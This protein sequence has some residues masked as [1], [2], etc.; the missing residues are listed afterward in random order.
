MSRQKSDPALTAL[1]IGGSVLMLGGF[2]LAVA[3]SRRVASAPVGLPRSSEPVPTPP[4]LHG[5]TEDDVEAAARMLASENGN[6]SRA[7][8]TELLGSQ[9]HARK[10]GESLYERITAGSGF[11]PQGEKT[12]PGKLRPVSTEQS[13]MPIHRS[14]ALEV[15][16]GLHTPRFPSAIAFFEPAQQD[17]VLRIAVRARE[18]RQQGLPLT[19]QEE[20]LRHYKKGA[21]DVRADWKQTMRIAGTIDGVEFYEMSRINPE[22][23]DFAIRAKAQRLA[24]PIERAEVMRVGDGVTDSRPGTGNPHDGVDI[25]AAPGTPIRAARSGRVKRVIDGRKSERE[26]ARKAGLWV[27]LEIGKQIDR[28]LHLDDVRV[29]EGQQVKRGDLIG[30]VAEAY[31]SG[32]GKGPH[33][34]F[35]VRASDYDRDK[36]DYGEPIQ[37]K[38]EVV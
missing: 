24:W 32:T 11:G 25:F 27:D 4:S 28:Y 17:K 19:A 3:F 5:Y 12:W 36:K 31:T 20:R 13:A 34:H 33:L 37:P 16:A 23:R 22:Q 15:L 18:K 10:P 1:A 8:W 2:A 38:F 35:E 7:L 30:F 26:A 9:L 21:D 6:G 14:F 29:A